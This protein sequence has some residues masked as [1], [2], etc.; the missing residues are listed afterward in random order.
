MGVGQPGVQ[1][2]ET[3]LSAIAEQQKD[4]G[5][6]EHRRLERSGTGD[7]VGPHHGI[8][9]RAHHRLGSHIDEDGAEQ[10]KRDADAR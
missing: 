4:E 5:E 7:E 9:A 6:I 8:E 3:D 2:K 1:G 10:R